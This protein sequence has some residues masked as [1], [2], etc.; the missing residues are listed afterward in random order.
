MRTNIIIFF[1]LFSCQEAPKEIPQMSLPVKAV[2]PG[3]ISSS[4]PAATL[5]PRAPITPP[6]KPP[7]PGV[8]KGCPASF[9][10]LDIGRECTFA[11]IK[12][13][14]GKECKFPVGSC[15]CE[16]QKTCSGMARSEKEMEEQRKLAPK[17]Y[18][19]AI[20]D[21]TILQSNGCPFVEPS[22]DCKTEG[23]FCSYGGYCGGMRTEALCK[24]GKWTLTSYM[25]PSPP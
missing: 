21:P 19:C 22:G 13:M 18:E 17:K 24:D 15:F 8:M 10:V 4:A 2:S 16:P 14:G 6:F 25:T 7:K 23:L 11:S 12:R 3:T 20:N 1:V 5:S 9:D